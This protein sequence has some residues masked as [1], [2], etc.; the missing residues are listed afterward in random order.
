[1]KLEVKVDKDPNYCTQLCRQYFK[2]FIDAVFQNKFK[3]AYEALYLCQQNESDHQYDTH[4]ICYYLLLKELLK[5][6]NV[7][8]QFPINDIELDSE[9][10]NYYVYFIRFQKA[11]LQ[12]NFKD[13][14]TYITSFSKLEK[15]KKGTNCMSSRI[16]RHL[17]NCILY[18]QKQLE[19]AILEQVD[20]EELEEQ[21]NEI[22]QSHI[23][24]ETLPMLEKLLRAKIKKNTDLEKNKMEQYAL[25][26]IEIIK[27]AIQ[28]RISRDSFQVSSYDSI[29]LVEKLEQVLNYGDY[30]SAA[31]IIHS[32]EWFTQTYRFPYSQK[33]YF[34]LYHKLLG[35]FER[36]LDKKIPKS[37]PSI[38]KENSDLSHLKT[39]S[40]F[41]ET[42][43]YASAY[44][45]YM[46]SSFEN[47]NPELKDML[48]FGLPFLK[49]NQQEHLINVSSEEK[50]MIK[51]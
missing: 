39:I 44:T 29:N 30:V 34:I 50:C 6:E 32:Q 42:E 8:L 31:T 41:L 38:P 37:N 28:K 36:I 14:R 43:D 24:E 47:I 13:A 35:I 27:F 2:Q 33:M 51:N 23:T 5:E 10:E 22:V 46:A 21:L 45:Y 3:E 4:N 20:E 40:T 25:D 19:Q 11:L 17:S 9:T 49:K 15:Q 16:F 7:E 18:R 12:S 1:M 26:I 48:E